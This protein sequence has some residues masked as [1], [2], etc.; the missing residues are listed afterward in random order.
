MYVIITPD[1]VF[2]YFESIAIARKVSEGP[3]FYDTRNED[4]RI[5]KL[6]TLRPFAVAAML[7]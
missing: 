4:I 6:T 2:G 5:E 1:A 3:H 7:S